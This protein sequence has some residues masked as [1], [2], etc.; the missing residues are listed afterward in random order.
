M[1]YCVAV[2]VLTKML[3]H[4]NGTI[5]SGLPSPQ[6]FCNG[7][8]LWVGQILYLPIYLGFYLSLLTWGIRKTFY[9]LQRA[10]FKSIL[11]LMPSKNL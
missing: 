4:K 7:F 2:V 8:F 3:C 1:Y 11:V 10:F 6:N 9:V 5:I